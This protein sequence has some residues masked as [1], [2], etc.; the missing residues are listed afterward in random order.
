MLRELGVRPPSRD[1]THGVV[2]VTVIRSSAGV[3]KVY[4]GSAVV[5][6]V[7]TSASTLQRRFGARK[8]I[9]DGDAKAEAKA[10]KRRNAGDALTAELRVLAKELA[11]E[12][13]AITSYYAVR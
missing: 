4:V 10:G 13:Y 1:Y 2:Y 8:S 12:E 6:R 11:P 9:V 5:W 3:V 7:T